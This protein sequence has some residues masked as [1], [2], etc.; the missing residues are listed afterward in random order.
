MITEAAWLLRRTPSA[1]R[2]VLAMVDAGLFSLLPLDAAAAS[3]ISLFLARYET[4]GAQLAD[5]ALMYLAEREGIDAI[6]TLDQRD[7]TVY[8]TTRGR[9][10]KI[11]PELS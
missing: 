10:M 6:F 2:D 3:S 1:I 9:R 4:L 5:A 11:V 7:F 8:R